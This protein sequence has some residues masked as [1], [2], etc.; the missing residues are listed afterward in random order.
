MLGDF[1]QIMKMCGE[2]GKLRDKVNESGIINDYKSI[3]KIVLIKCDKL[4]LI[5][6]LGLF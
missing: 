3:G 4:L 2:Y 6:I 5:R 1:N